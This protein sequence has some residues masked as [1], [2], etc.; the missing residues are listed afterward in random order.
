MFSPGGHQVQLRPNSYN[1]PLR[2]PG[3]EGGWNSF[4]TLSMLGYKNISLILSHD[5]LFENVYI[6]TPS[7]GKYH[8]VHYQSKQKIRTWKT[9]TGWFSHFW[10]ILRSK[11]KGKSVFGSD[12][13]LSWLEFPGIPS[14]ETLRSQVSLGRFLCLPVSDWLSWQIPSTLLTLL[15]FPAFHILHNN[16]HC[17]CTYIRTHSI[18]HHPLL[19][20]WSHLTHTVIGKKSVWSRK[21]NSAACAAKCLWRFS[22]IPKCAA[23]SCHYTAFSGKACAH[24]QYRHH[25]WRFQT[26]VC[27]MWAVCLCCRACGRVFSHPCFGLVSVQYLFFLISGF[28]SG[29]P[30]MEYSDLRLFTATLIGEAQQGWKNAALPS[31]CDYTVPGCMWMAVELVIKVVKCKWHTMYIITTGAVYTVEM[32]ISNTVVTMLAI[33]LCWIYFFGCL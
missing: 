9:Y 29:Q 22:V 24:L 33:G 8:I 10:F 14:E 16:T 15:G 11:K 30:N 32:I 18:I 6:D 13:N 28:L 2:Q 21:L 4:S 26:F 25:A 17:P 1:T 27:V 20:I 12:N 3:Q 19:A 7:C 31:C 5:P 23:N